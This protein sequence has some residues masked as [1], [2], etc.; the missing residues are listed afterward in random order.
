VRRVLIAALGVFLIGCGDES[1]LP[2]VELAPPAPVTSSVTLAK[3]AE[4]DA[5]RAELAVLGLAE[6]RFA[7]L[8][9]ESSEDGRDPS[10]G[11]APEVIA[12]SPL[13]VNRETPKNLLDGTLRALALGDVAALAR[14]SR[15]PTRSPQ[16]NQDDA[17]DARRR[18]LT[19]SGRAYWARIAKAIQQ[20]QFDVN[21]N[22][23][24]AV[25]QLEVGGAAGSY[26]VRMRKEIDG[27]YLD[28]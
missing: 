20:G 14:L 24:T 15:D 10:L 25:V 23:Q 17:T 4:V 13:R 3:A 22:D 9:S 18:F 8:D 19:S 1:P 11:P 2:P 27:W 21:G 26:R 28:G 12:E 5:A 6:L 7:A 16:L